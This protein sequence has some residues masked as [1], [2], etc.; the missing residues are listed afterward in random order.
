MTIVPCHQFDS[1]AVSGVALLHHVTETG[2]TMWK[3]PIFVVLAGALF[4]FCT[5][6]TA[7]AAT[8]HHY[9]PHYSSY[10]RNYGYNYGYHRGYS[11]Y[12]GNRYSSGGTS[13][14]QN[15]MALKL[16]IQNRIRML[17][18]NREWGQKLKADHLAVIAEHADKNLLTDLRHFRDQPTASRIASGAALNYLVKQFGSKLGEIDFSKVKLST[19]ELASVRLQTADGITIDHLSQTEDA[20]GKILWPEELQFE[21]FA[22]HRTSIQESLQKLQRL[23]QEGQPVETQVKRVEHE[24]AALRSLVGTVLRDEKQDEIGANAARDFL[25]QLQ[26]R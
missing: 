16:A 25:R 20:S 7:P 11:G 12:R 18:F 22:Q 5:A 9:H 13:A 26:T 17:E 2:A 23:D 10:Y 19:A 14:I 4:Y 6:S 24:I 15:Q 21:E 3:L 1:C 8:H